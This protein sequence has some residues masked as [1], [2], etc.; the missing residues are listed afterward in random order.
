MDEQN[1]Q[2]QNQLQG[3]QVTT[4]VAVLQNLVTAVNELA[5]TISQSKLNN[6]IGTYAYREVDA[7][8]GV[9]YYGYA[10]AGSS[11]ADAAWSIKK[12]TSVGG[13][14][15]VVWADGDLSYDNIWNDYATLTYS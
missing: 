12:E 10:I 1:S 5:L 7:G 2:F 14:V 15:T 11:A 13:A 9:K 3:Q 8:S 6:A 4:I